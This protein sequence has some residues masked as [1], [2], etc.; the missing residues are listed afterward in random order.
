LVAEGNYPVRS[1]L[2]PDPN[3]PLRFTEEWT[4][5]NKPLDIE[6]KSNRT[7]R[8]GLGVR[9]KIL[10]IAVHAEAFTLG[11]YKGYCGGLSVG[12]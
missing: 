8:M 9:A 4:S 6:T 2:T 10:M 3:N 1:G 11:E 7:L 12:F 5:L